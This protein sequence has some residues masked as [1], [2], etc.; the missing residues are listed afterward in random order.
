MRDNPQMSFLDVMKEVGLRWGQLPEEDKEPFKER[1][2]EDKRRF[3]EE[4]ESF[5]R[6]RFAFPTN[7]FDQR[8]AQQGMPMPKR[9]LTGFQ[10]FLRE[11][12]EKLKKDNP[13]MPMGEFM[14]HVSIEWTR[15]SQEEK[16][17]YERMVAKDRQRFDNEFHEYQRNM[18]LNESNSGMFFNGKFG[19]EDPDEYD[20]EDRDFKRPDDGGEGLLP[21]DLF[22]E[23]VESFSE[24]ETGFVNP[25]QLAKMVERR[26]VEKLGE[27][28][29]LSVIP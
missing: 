22:Q 4:T 2:M 17:H 9:P 6:Q 11:T 5:V 21:K 18:V 25:S 28:S 7:T 29:V 19:D 8:L 15:M 27:D 14:R 10:F 23:G 16:K 26:K 3:L 12:R 13:K 1:S 24:L 20:Q